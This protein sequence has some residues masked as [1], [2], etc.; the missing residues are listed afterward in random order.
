MKLSARDIHVFVAGALALWGA[1]ALL[2]FPYFFFA[3]V[4]HDA[5]WAGHSFYS[6]SA[7]GSLLFGLA[8]LFGKRWA[9]LAAQIWLWLTLAFS[10]VVTS[11]AAFILGPSR[12]LTYV[13]INFPDLI[14]CVVLLLLIYLS[15]SQK[16][17]VDRPHLSS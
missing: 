4:V 16:F 6:L 3:P 5:V 1:R 11:R 9:I 12:A 10:A 15:R 17:Q 7:G 14:I 2:Y 8:I 13:W